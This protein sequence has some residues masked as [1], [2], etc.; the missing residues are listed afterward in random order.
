MMSALTASATSEQE[1]A[2]SSQ[3]IAPP[4]QV[5]PQNER[6]RAGHELQQLIQQ[7]EQLRDPVARALV[8]ECLRNLVA[9]YG[10]G[11][12]RILEV[13]KGCGPSGEY[14]HGQL[15]EDPVVRGLLLIHGLHPVDLSTRLN[16]AIEKVRPYMENHG[17]SV[18]LLSLK[19]DFARFRLRGACRTCP[20]SSVTMELTLRQ[21]IEEICPDLAGFEVENEP[22]P[23]S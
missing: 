17:G 5:T 16:Q 15:V 20:S 4:A 14:V 7:A 12:G 8:P 9:F 11:L 10:D 1:T 3:P 21:A 22:A 6:L 13:V 23:H 18:E 2:P 19:S